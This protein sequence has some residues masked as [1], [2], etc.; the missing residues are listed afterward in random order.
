MSWRDAPLYVEAFDLARWVAERAGKWQHPPMAEL[1]TRSACDLLATVALA[2]TFPRARHQH[3]GQADAGIVRLRMLLR[4]A[5]SLGLLSGGGLRY[6]AGRLQ[7]IGRMVGGWRKRL[8]R[9]ED[10][11]TGGDRIAEA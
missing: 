9:R 3:P 1:A 5:Q 7:A 4:L 8:R 11:R 2:L 10:C 6:A